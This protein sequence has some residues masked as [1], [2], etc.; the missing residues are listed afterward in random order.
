MSRFR[1]YLK[2]VADSDVSGL[3]KAE[4]SY[5]SSWKRRGGVGAFMML[6]RKWDR[7]EQRVTAHTDAVGSVSGPAQ[8]ELFAHIAA[9]VIQ[10]IDAD[11]RVE[12][13]I[14]DI[15]DLRRYLTLVE[16]EMVA[17]GEV[18]L[19]TDSEPLGAET[20]RVAAPDKLVDS[21]KLYLDYL[22]PVALSDVN[23][24]TQPD[25]SYASIWLRGKGANAFKILAEKWDRIEQRLATDMNA[26]GDARA[27]TRY[28]VFEHI[29]ADRRERNILNDIR[30][31]RRYLMLVEAETAARGAVKIGSARDNREST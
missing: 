6:A 19:S 10:H 31:L 30:D 20:T 16:A 9:D 12:G 15:R 14:D 25:Q 27:A 26:K 21:G 8:R 1:K 4:Q 23:S 17:R 11:R 29:V 2:P 3:K 7:I 24:I 13:I 5:G 28:D 22:R 18:K